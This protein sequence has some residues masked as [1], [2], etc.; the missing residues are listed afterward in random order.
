MSKCVNKGNT[1]LADQFI[2]GGIGYGSIC[3]PDSL[4]DMII[5]IIFPPM[6]VILYQIKQKKMNMGQL[7]LNFVLTS[8]FYFPG[9]IHAMYIMKQKKLCGSIF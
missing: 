1:N 6:Y 4:L 5:V 7:I 2:N 9:F 3:M 8:F